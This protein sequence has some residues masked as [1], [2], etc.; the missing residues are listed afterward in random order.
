M[1]SFIAALRSLVLPFGATSGQRIVLDGVNGAI[2]VYNSSGVEIGRLDPTTL[3]KVTGAQTTFNVNPNGNTFVRSVP[4]QGGYVAVSASPGFGG[5]IQLQPEDS[6]IGGVVF[7]PAAVYADSIEAGADSTPQLQLDSPRISPGGGMARFALRGQTNT[8][9]TNNSL[10]SL[11]ADFETFGTVR[12]NDT[13]VGEGCV[14]NSGLTASSPGKGATESIVITSTEYEFKANRAYKVEF[15][16]QMS[17]SVATGVNGVA[18]VRR[19]D[20]SDNP[21]TGQQINTQRFFM[22]ATTAGL[23]Y[24]T[25]WSCYLRIGAANITTQIALSLQ[26]GAAYTV[27][28][29]CSATAPAMFQIYDV[30]RAADFPFAR[31]MT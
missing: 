18:R 2:V 20:G 10:A 3:F 19:H 13:Y 12:I 23:P 22:P 8:S 11:T 30:G 9:G 28:I 24:G 6:S 16:G 29:S 7:L 25:D 27:N 15:T 5:V 4:D 14:A 17:A 1:K 31:V 26:G 21:P